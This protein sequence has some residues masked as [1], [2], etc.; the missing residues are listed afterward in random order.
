MCGEE[1]I[2]KRSLRTLIADYAY[3][4]PLSAVMCLIACVGLEHFESDS[5]FWGIFRLLETMDEIVEFQTTVLKNNFK[6]H[7]IHTPPPDLLDKFLKMFPKVNHL[8]LISIR[9][10]CLRL[11]R[12]MMPQMNITSLELSADVDTGGKNCY[13]FKLLHVAFEECGNKLT[14]LKLEK[15]LYVDI[16]FLAENCKNLRE[17]FLINNSYEIFPERIPNLFKELTELQVI[18]IRNQ[19]AD[20]IRKYFLSEIALYSL[21]SSKRLKKLLV[22]CQ[23]FFSDTVMGD[24]FE[25]E[26]LLYLNEIFIYHCDRI[27]DLTLFELVH[28]TRPIEKVEIGFSTLITEDM[29]QML[30]NHI[31]EMKLNVSVSHVTKDPY[32]LRWSVVDLPISDRDTFHLDDS[33]LHINQI[34]Q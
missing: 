7:R 21:L 14:S 31:K 23:D 22:C 27:T 32:F 15:F 30:K 4:S 6:T 11:V 29:M 3:E 1:S 26:H 18:F 25:G 5:T 10:S 16:L 28:N 13:T 9:K 2:V 20:N 8:I 12:Q 17:L 19:V 33:A 34:F 24:L